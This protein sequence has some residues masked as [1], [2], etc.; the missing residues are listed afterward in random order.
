MYFGYVSF[1]SGWG[2]VAVR[3][4]FV[5][6]V[7]AALALAGSVLF[8]PEDFNV[9]KAG[10]FV[11]VEPKEWGTPQVWVFKGGVEGA[12]LRHLGINASFEGAPPALPYALKALVD[13]L[14]PNATATGVFSSKPPVAYAVVRHRPTLPAV[15]TNATIIVFVVPWGPEEWA[16]E[17]V[18]KYLDEINT[19]F[20]K[21]KWMNKTVGVVDKAMEVLLG[22]LCRERREAVERGLNRFGLSCGRPVNLTDIEVRRRV[23]A[24]LA[25]LEWVPSVWAAMHERGALGVPTYGVMFAKS[26]CAN[27]TKAELAKAVREA[28]GNHSLIFELGCGIGGG[29]LDVLVKDYTPIYKEPPRDVEAWLAEQLAK[30][31]AYE[32]SGMSAGSQ[33]VGGNTQPTGATGGETSATAGGLIGAVVLAAVAVAVAAA[34][35]A[36]RRR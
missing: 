29:R 22:Q 17:N 23:W 15:E 7:L 2:G 19:Y 33:R 1:F 18:T 6:L 27:M 5:V 8:F 11:V 20:A 9:T 25:T 14:F 10:P 24:V 4:A 28:A 16:G 26:V 13:S 30:G 35:V 12:V 3:A 34:Y 21:T 36:L 31:A 32:P